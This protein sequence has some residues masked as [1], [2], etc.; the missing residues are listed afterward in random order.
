MAK[1]IDV[2]LFL[3]NFKEK[4]KIWSILYRDD[5]GKNTATLTALEIRPIDRTKVLENLEV[6]DYSEGP[7]PEVLY[8]GADMWV[9]GTTIKKKEIYIKITMGMNRSSVLCISFHIAEQ[10][11]NYP[12]K[13]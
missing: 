5:R 13:K 7:K 12:F 9:F 3:K 1:K 4:M 8:S 2:E 10:T 6:P 11:M